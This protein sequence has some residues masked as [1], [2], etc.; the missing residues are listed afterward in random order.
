[1]MRRQI[2]TGSC[3]RKGNSEQVKKRL[4][5]ED[6]ASDRVLPG[7]Q[8]EEQQHSSMQTLPSVRLVDY[9]ISDTDCLCLSH[10]HGYL[11]LY[12]N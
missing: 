7:H 12:L 6:R 1:M 4:K 3:P 8:T 11:C 9:Q 2:I 10:H 5:I